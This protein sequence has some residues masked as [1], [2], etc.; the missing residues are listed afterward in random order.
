MT[1]D[2]LYLSG[3]MLSFCSL[4]YIILTD[5]EIKFDIKTSLDNQPR[6]VQASMI[7]LGSLLTSIVWPVNLIMLVISR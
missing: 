3:M 1:L 6:S 2:L 5:D 4:L 7:I